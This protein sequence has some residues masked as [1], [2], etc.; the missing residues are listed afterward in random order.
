MPQPPKDQ[1]QIYYEDYYRFEGRSHWMEKIWSEAFGEAYPAGLEHY[2]YLTRGDLDIF[3][4]KLKIPEGGTLLD[5]GCGKGGPGLKLAERL[6]LKLTGIDIIPE[7]VEQAK[8][9]QNQFKL[10][11]SARFALGN[12]YEIPLED[13]SVDAIISFDSLWAATHK[14]LALREAKRVMKPGG[15]FIF[16][17]WDLIANDQAHVLEVASG[18]TLVDR[19]ETPDWKTYQQKV[20]A[21]IL[22]YQNE[23]VEEMGQG[24]NM[25]LHEAHT[26]PPYLDLSIRRIYHWELK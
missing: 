17:H 26:S 13:N 8:S 23:L 10:D 9:F 2:G 4:E 25:L 12:F 1:N 21:G 6:K 16:T 20:Y 3:A 22:K 24:A 18:L 11:F 7:A 19:I 15:E 14:I 5:I